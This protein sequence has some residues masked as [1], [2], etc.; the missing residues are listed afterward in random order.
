MR[1]RFLPLDDR[2][3]LRRILRAD[4][5]TLETG[6]PGSVVAAPPN[7]VDASSVRVRLLRLGLLM[8][9]GVRIEFL[10]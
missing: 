3:D 9:T 8:S 1:V 10:A 5:W 2:V 7:A 4:G 6:R